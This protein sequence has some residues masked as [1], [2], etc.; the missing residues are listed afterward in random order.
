MT[1]VDGHQVEGLSHD[2]LRRLL[3]EYNRLAN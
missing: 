2:E 3:R 1:G